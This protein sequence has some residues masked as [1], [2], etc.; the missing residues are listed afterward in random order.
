MEYGIYNCKCLAPSV[1]HGFVRFCSIVSVRS[2]RSVV[3][4]VWYA[5][6]SELNINWAAC[7]PKCPIKL[8]MKI[9]IVSVRTLS[10][11]LPWIH[12]QT[13]SNSTWDFQKAW[14]PILDP[15]VM[16]QQ[17]RVTSLHDHYC[18][19]SSYRS[20]D[21]FSYLRIFDLKSQQPPS[22]RNV[23]D[24]TYTTIE[25]V[26]YTMK[27]SPSLKSRE[28]MRSMFRSFLSTEK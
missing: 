7:P 26:C 6:E 9:Q 4:K 14:P 1:V 19:L 23:G 21:V 2:T 5:E 16:L 27:G 20:L 11:V 13:R 3:L 17:V 24:Q 15:T 10:F 28:M 12:L 25:N 8:L 22:M 18:V